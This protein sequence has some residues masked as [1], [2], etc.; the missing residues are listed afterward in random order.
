MFEFLKQLVTQDK[1][2]VVILFVDAENSTV[3]PVMISERVESE[4]GQP[5]IRRAYAK[6]SAN[7]LVKNPLNQYRDE[8]FECIT[9]DSG[10]NNADIMLSVDAVDMMHEFGNN[11]KRTLIICADGDRG[12]AHVFDKARKLGW[13]S[14]LFANEDRGSLSDILRN[15]AD[16][17]FSPKCGPGKPSQKKLHEELELPTPDELIAWTR[18]KILDI[19]TGPT[20]YST[21][22]HRLRAKMGQ[23]NWVIEKPR[24]LA[25]ECGFKLSG[26]IKL[27]SFFEE[28]FGDIIEIKRVGPT[29]LLIIPKHV[30][31]HETPQ[32]E[33]S[34]GGG[35]WKLTERNSGLEFP[36]N[37]S[38]T[39]KILLFVYDLMSSESIE[40]FLE[41]KEIESGSGEED[42]T[43][44][45]IAE[46]ISGKY[47]IEQENVISVIKGVLKHTA[48]GPFSAPPKLGELTPLTDLIE[49]MRNG[50]VRFQT[51][52]KN[53]KEWEQPPHEWVDQV[54]NYFTKVVQIG[55]KIDKKKF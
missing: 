33:R 3:P 20:D 42:L 51:Q 26:N 47:Y 29:K 49:A 22:H 14:V 54:D 15:A 45:L 11:G 13:K 36:V 32:P 46:K 21:F 18:E 16:V 53:E 41:E 23:R 31:K 4:C 43:W 6:W 17:V 55:I 9:C 39:A 40:V 10:P 19:V 1:E 2:E 25:V 44:V 12:F 37:P 8:G 52:H 50:I 28:K 24:E 27:Y 38:D 5:R 34:T 7:P 35:I 30:E 48:A